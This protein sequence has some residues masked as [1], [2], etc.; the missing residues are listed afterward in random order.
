MQNEVSKSTFEI[1]VFEEW[2]DWLTWNEMDVRSFMAMTITYKE[3]WWG[4]WMYRIV[5]VVTSYVGEPS[6]YLVDFHL[7]EFV[8]LPYFYMHVFYVS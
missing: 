8:D 1:S 6:T 4:E 5:T 7:L 3:P 2:E